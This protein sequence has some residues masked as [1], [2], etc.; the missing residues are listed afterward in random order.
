MTLEPVNVEVKVRRLHGLVGERL[1]VDRDDRGRVGHDARAG[2][3]AEGR[4]GFPG[5][6]CECRTVPAAIKNLI[7]M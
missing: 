6:C 5:R 4:R 7:F 3:H 1:L 2:P